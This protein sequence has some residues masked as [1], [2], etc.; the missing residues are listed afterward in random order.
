MRYAMLINGVEQEWSQ[1]T[2]ADR[3]N[4]MAAIGKWFDT[5]SAAGKIGA[6]NAQLD[7]VDTARTIRSDSNGAVV[8]TDGPYIELK[9]VIGGIVMLTADSLDEAVQIASGWPSLTGS[10]SIEVRP[11]IDM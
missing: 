6:G 11:T 1:A 4:A 10:T 8:V 2:A 3:D 5:W 7:S 9:E